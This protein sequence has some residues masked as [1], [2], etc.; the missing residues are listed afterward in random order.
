MDKGYCQAGDASRLMIWI[1]YLTKMN[2]AETVAYYFVKNIRR[3]QY[4]AFR[5]LNLPTGSGCVESAIRRV[6]NLRL[7]SPGIFWKRETAEVML[8]LRSTLL[9]G[10]WHN[11]LEHL[12]QLN[13]GQFEVC[14]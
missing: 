14:P 11:M 1:G 7:K 2:S 13:R 12:L 6:I 8:F 9:C 4:A 3:M 10:R 5:W